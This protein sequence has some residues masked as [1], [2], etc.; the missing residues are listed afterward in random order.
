MKAYLTTADYDKSK[1][2]LVVSPPHFEGKELLNRRLVPSDHWLPTEHVKHVILLLQEKF[3][4][5]KKFVQ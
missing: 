5:G 1:F 2:S 4:C 3:Q